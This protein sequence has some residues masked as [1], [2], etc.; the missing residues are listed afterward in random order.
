MDYQQRN[1][2]EADL[3]MER[4]EVVGWSAI[5]SDIESS[6]NLVEAHGDNLISVTDLRTLIMSG[7]S[8]LEELKREQEAIN[9]RYV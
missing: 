8:R 4:V 7:R 9:R 5:V 6:L 2:L 1:R 3:R